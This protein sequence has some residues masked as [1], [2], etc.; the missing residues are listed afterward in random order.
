MRE[1][2][3]NKNYAERTSIDHIIKIEG[4]RKETYRKDHVERVIA[5][6]HWGQPPR[7]GIAVGHHSDVAGGACAGHRLQAS[8]RG[9]PE[10]RVILQFRLQ[11]IADRAI[12]GPIV[13]VSVDSGIHQPSIPRA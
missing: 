3:R 11:F 2:L 4:A 9:A 10:S 13:P 7:C 8:P 1:R 5:S 12:L 6:C